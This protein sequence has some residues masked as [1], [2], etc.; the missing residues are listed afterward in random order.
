MGQSS[1]GAKGAILVS[2]DDVSAVPTRAFAGEGDTLNSAGHLGVLFG[3]DGVAL[4]GDHV[5]QD[6]VV[7][8][9]LLEGGGR[10]H[11]SIRW[12]PKNPSTFQ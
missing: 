4:G 11:G 2:D 1:S 5:H 8:A 12:T 7:G 9:E 6:A 3:A 10:G